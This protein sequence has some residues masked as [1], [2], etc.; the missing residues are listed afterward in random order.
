MIRL[1]G[2]TG[3]WKASPS[4]RRK[5]SADWRFAKP[6][7]SH[8]YRKTLQAS[9]SECRRPLRSRASQLH[10]RKAL[11]QIQQRNLSLEARKLGSD[12]KMQTRTERQVL[13][14]QPLQI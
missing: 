9:E 14:V 4:Y 6:R 5:T 10:L 1:C 3:S 7:P 8:N 12:A 13:V 11:H 2:L